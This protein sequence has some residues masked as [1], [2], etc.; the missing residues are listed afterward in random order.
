MVSVHSSKTLTNVLFHWG[1]TRQPSSIYVL[2][3]SD[4]LVYTFWLVANG[5]DLAGIQVA[6]HHW[7]S[8]GIA[9]PF[10]SFNPSPNSF[11]GILT[12][13]QCLFVF[14]LDGGRASQSIAMLGSYLQVQHSIMLGF[15]THPRD[16]SQVGLIIYWPFIQSLL[17]FCPCIFQSE[18]IMSEEEDQHGI[19]EVSWLV[20]FSTVHRRQSKSSKCGE[21]IPFKVW[22]SSPY[23]LPQGLTQHPQTGTTTGDPISKDMCLHWYISHLN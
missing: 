10:S 3:A 8:F 22:A 13:V 16:G 17:H 18:C 15:G 6:W 14:V 11:I 20:T 4:Q 21:V 7:S 12:L 9:T 19:C 2:G 1:Q 23:F 5:W